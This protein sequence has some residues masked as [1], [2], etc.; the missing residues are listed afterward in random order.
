MVFSEEGTYDFSGPQLLPITGTY[1]VDKDQIVFIE[2]DGGGCA[3]IPGTYTWKFRDNAL[4]LT[5]IED[6]CSIRRIDWQA[7]EWN[8]QE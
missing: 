2:T 6:A 3:G 1:T 7:G 4:T 8:M 5:P